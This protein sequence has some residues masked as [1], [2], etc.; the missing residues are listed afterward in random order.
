MLYNGAISH[1]LM[2][3]FYPWNKGLQSW[4][5]LL[6]PPSEYNSRKGCTARLAES[7]PY[8]RFKHY[9]F[10]YPFSDLAFTTL[11]HHYLGY[12]GNNKYFLKIISNRHISLSFP[13]FVI[14]YNTNSDQNEQIFTRFET[15]LFQTPRKS[16]LQTEKARTRVFAYLLLWIGPP[17]SKLKQLTSKTCRNIK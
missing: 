9:I 12:N 17:K 16:G 13:S 5:V 10:H 11:R 1:D 14:E 15:S 3:A 6:Y 7:W 8:F 2:T 4:G